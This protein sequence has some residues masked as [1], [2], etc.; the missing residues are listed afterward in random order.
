MANPFFNRDSI[1]NQNGGFFPFSMIN[2]FNSFKQKFTGDPK[3]Q[4]L[5]LIA[6]GKMSQEQFDQLS[7]MAQQFQQFIGK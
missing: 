7:Y 2:E 1:G 5:N 6:S 3:Q 4:V